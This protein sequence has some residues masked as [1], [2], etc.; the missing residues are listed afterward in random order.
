MVRKLLAVCTLAVMVGAVAPAADEEKSV[1]E[2]VLSLKGHTILAS[3]IRETELAKQLRE[4][5][6][7]T[8][9]APT[10]AAFRKLGDDRVRSLVADPKRLKELVLAHVVTGQAV[11]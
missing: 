5:G 7:M 3:A 9:F 4:K 6:P 10:D 2:T 1:A 8:L 11:Y